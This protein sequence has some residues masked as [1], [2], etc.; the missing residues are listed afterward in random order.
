MTAITILNI[1]VSAFVV[2]GILALMGWGIA[3]DRITAG[4]LQARRRARA[5]SVRGLHPAF[6]LR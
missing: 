2:V 3:T 1:L 6:D 5:Q 4:R